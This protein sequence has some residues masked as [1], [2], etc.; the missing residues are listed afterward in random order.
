MV[1]S[2]KSI[3]GE[4]FWRYKL[5][6]FFTATGLRCLNCILQP[7]S[8]QYRKSEHLPLSSKFYRDLRFVTRRRWGVLYLLDCIEPRAN[9]PP[10]A[11]GIRSAKMDSSLT[12]VVRVK[13]VQKQLTWKYWKFCFFRLKI[14][15]EQQINT[16]RARIIQTWRGFQWRQCD[17]PPRNRKCARITLTL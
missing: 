4:D 1:F 17:I 7:T 12:H 15:S 8:F 6:E 13:A 3:L 9:P 10:S 2:R 14:Y 16:S 5:Y 11:R